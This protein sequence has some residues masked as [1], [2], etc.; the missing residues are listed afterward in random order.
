MRSEPCFSPSRLSKPS[1]ERGVEDLLYYRT[2]LDERVKELCSHHSNAALIQLSLNIP[3]PDKKVFPAEGLY[4][5]GIEAVDK[6]IVIK[7]LYQERKDWPFYA[8]FFVVEV[9][10]EELK[11][12]CLDL[13]ETHPLGRFWDLDVY[14]QDGR[15][16]SREML[17]RKER[18]CFL[19][20]SPAKVCAFLQRHSDVELL[21]YIQE[22]YV[23][24]MTN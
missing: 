9:N 23:G 16:V 8:A 7:D 5:A 14:R 6:M 19:C 18:T 22:T 24:Q 11:A 21:R 2:C 17:N 4:H 10:P 12:R 15:K 1:Y 20:S 3:G 13:E